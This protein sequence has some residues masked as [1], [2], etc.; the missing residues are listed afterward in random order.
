MNKLK[1]ICVALCISSES[2]PLNLSDII[3]WYMCWK[4]CF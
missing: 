4:T 2:E 3:E 1:H